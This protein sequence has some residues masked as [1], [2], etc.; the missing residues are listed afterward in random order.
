M[1]SFSAYLKWAVITKVSDLKRYVVEFK[2]KSEHMIRS[3][4]FFGSIISYIFSLTHRGRN[5]R[6]DPPHVICKVKLPLHAKALG[7]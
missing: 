4:R 7:L 2:Y 1:G 5:A 3:K 6:W